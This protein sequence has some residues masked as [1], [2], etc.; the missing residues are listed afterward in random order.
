MLGLRYLDG[1]ADW[2]SRGPLHAGFGNNGWHDAL[3]QGLGSRQV[4]TVQHWLP[5]KD[6]DVWRLE[7]G[8][9]CGW[10]QK[11]RLLHL[12]LRIHQ[13]VHDGGGDGNRRQEVIRDLGKKPQTLQLCCCG[14]C[15][16]RTTPSSCRLPSLPSRA[17]NPQDIEITGAGNTGFHSG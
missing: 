11:Q 1:I 13:R 3:S 14:C 10:C 5:C 7:A 4:A 12:R 17:L 16:Q 6:R 2:C 8:C 15:R 9:T